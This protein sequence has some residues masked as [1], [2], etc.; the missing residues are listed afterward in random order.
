[1]H[2]CIAW[3]KESMVAAL[4]AMFIMIALMTFSIFGWVRI[5][6]VEAGAITLILFSSWAG[7]AIYTAPC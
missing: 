4:F 1:M 3:M 2:V 6:I 7:A 5:S